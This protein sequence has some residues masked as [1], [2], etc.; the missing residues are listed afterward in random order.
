MIGAI[1]MLYVFGVVGL[2][3][4]WAL[5]Q[6]FFLKNGDTRQTVFVSLSTVPGWFLSVRNMF[7]FGML[8]ISDGL[9]VS[10]NCIG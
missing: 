8:L 7:M 4:D 9:K 3:F 6:W 1:S 10:K 2:G 5:L